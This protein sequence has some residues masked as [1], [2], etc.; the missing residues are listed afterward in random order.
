M[1][2][3]CLAET[4]FCYSGVLLTAATANAASSQQ[5]QAHYS[6]FSCEFLTLCCQ[7]S[8]PIIIREESSPGPLGLSR[9]L[10]KPLPLDGL[11]EDLPFQPHLVAVVEVLGQ[12]HALAQHAL[13]AVVHRRKVAVPV[14]VVAAAI[15][16]LDVL[17][18]GALLCLEVPGPRVDVWSKRGHRLISA[19][20]L[21]YKFPPA[22]P[23]FTS[24]HGY[25]LTALMMYHLMMYPSHE[26]L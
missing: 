23:F 21:S 7:P 25:H 5:S 9:T 12:L 18:E 1:G 14:L 6:I 20:S 4:V 13:Q 3:L 11:G 15:E 24:L 17:P 26:G 22:S 19:T 2:A 16:L 10:Q 8:P